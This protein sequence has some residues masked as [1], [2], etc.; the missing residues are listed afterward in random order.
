[1][2]RYIHKPT[3]IW[4]IQNTPENLAEI[5]K[6]GRWGKLSVVDDLNPYDWLIKNGRGCYYII[7]QDSFSEY[8]EELQEIRSND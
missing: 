7:P 4:A 5:E 3:I 1:M 8:Y 2:R 6:L